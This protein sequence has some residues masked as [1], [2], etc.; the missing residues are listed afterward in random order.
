MIAT[1]IVVLSLLGQGGGIRPADAALSITQTPIS[2]AFEFKMGG[3]LPRI[4]SASELHGATPYA[5]T[6]GSGSMLLAEIEVDRQ[7]WREIGSLG[8][9]VSV[10]YAEKYGWAKL[11]DGTVSSERTALMVVPIKALAVYR[12]DYAAERWRIPLV[13]YAKAGLAFTPYWIT[14][15]GKLEFVN[16]RRGAG[17]NWG[18]AGV[19]GLSFLL[20]VLE[21]RLARDFD[22]DLGVNHSYLFAEFVIQDVRSFGARTFDLSSRHWMFGLTLEY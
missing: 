16:G 21:P 7:L 14:K 15:G 11:D 22:S 10:G 13:P 20:D 2:G 19:L 5:D 6:F 12:F 17:T 4:D 18:L 1:G 3:Y 9:G 8:V